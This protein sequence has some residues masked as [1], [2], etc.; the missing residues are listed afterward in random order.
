MRNIFLLIF[1][2]QS[3]E[4]KRRIVEVKKFC[5][6][7]KKLINDIT[8]CIL[9]KQLEK[10]ARK[11]IPIVRKRER[12]DTDMIVMDSKCHLLFLKRKNLFFLFSVNRF[13]LKMISIFVIAIVCEYD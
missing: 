10:R 9:I 3:D 6:Q 12:I 7:K 5:K 13:V 8:C 2:L 4:R 11:K 1:K